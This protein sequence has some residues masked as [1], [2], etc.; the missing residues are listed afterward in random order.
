MA[1]VSAFIRTSKTDRNKSVNVRF[2]LRDG[3]DFQLFHKSELTVSPERWD[4]RQQKIKARATIDT[5]ERNDFDKAIT[6]RKNLIMDVFLQKGKT[7]TSDL[8]DT[9]IEKVLHPERYEVPQLTFFDLYDK[10]VD[11]ISVSPET[12]KKRHTVRTSLIRFEK[13]EK[14]TLNI[15]TVTAETLKSFER[16]LRYEGQQD[17]SQPVRSSNTVSG[18]IKVVRTFFLWCE[19]NEY[20]SNRPFARY[21]VPAEKYG[22]PFYITIDE[23]NELYNFDLS[24]HPALERQRDIFVF[25][26]VIGCRVGDLYRLTRNSV[27]NGAIQYIP[28]KTKGKEP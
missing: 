17:E 3:R 10:F 13:H 28:E 8:L 2:R 16:F 9:E 6:D 24:G 15:D 1:T 11:V 26:C 20:T 14:I 19:R 25:Q 18:M 4:E 23:R 5:K 7:L 22:T 21:K 12:L 27:I